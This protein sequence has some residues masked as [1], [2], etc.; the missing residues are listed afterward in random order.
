MASRGNAPIITPDERDA[1]YEALATE[2]VVA[3]AA[4]FNR[5]PRTVGHLQ[6]ARRRLGLPVVYPVGRQEAYLRALARRANDRPAT[7]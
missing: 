6:M 4:R 2:S 1:I 7:D 3:V 5:H